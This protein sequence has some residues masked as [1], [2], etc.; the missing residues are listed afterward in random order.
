LYANGGQAFACSAHITERL[1]WTLAWVAFDTQ[2]LQLQQTSL[3]KD[4]K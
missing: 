2:Q 4:G 3:E 1:R